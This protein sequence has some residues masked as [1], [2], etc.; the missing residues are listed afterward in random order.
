MLGVNK[1]FDPLLLEETIRYDDKE[2]NFDRIVAA[3]LAIALANKLDPIIGA[4][5][6][7][8]DE[9]IKSLGRKRPANILFPTGS[10][11][12]VSRKRKLFT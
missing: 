11:L 5:R 10:N 9:R 6:E 7:D 8:A 4:V 1:I 12:F 2:G 3:E